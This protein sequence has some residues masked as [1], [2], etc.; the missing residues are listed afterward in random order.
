MQPFDAF[1][2]VMFFVLAVTLPLVGVFPHETI[3]L[4]LLTR[5]QSNVYFGN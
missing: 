5:A 1:M 2:E 4:V 3:A